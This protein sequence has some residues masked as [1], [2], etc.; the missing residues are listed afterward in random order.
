MA[1]EIKDPVFAA[2]LVSKGCE[3]K[4]ICPSSKTEPKLYLF[5]DAVKEEQHEARF[6]GCKT[7][8]DKVA[9][10]DFITSMRR[11]IQ[12]EDLRLREMSDR[13]NKTGWEIYKGAKVFVT[14]DQAIAAFILRNSDKKG[15]VALDVQRLGK[16]KGYKFIFDDPNKWAESAVPRMLE[17]HNFVD[18]WWNMKCDFKLATSI[19]RQITRDLADL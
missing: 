5:D 16:D 18:T 2:Y 19:R 12:L 13:P 10:R 14:T 7:Q 6:L 9:W 8:R 1:L 3:L 11:L 15:I 17:G 4:G